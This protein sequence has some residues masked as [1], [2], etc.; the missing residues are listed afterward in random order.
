L[1]AIDNNLLISQLEADQ[2]A[3]PDEVLW[4]RMTLTEM[5]SD[6]PE[7]MNNTEQLLAQCSFTSTLRQ[8]KIKP[9]LQTVIT[10][11]SNCF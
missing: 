9:H 5:F 6:L 11:I 8:L 4:S 10:Q 2:M 3:H 1:R 7:L